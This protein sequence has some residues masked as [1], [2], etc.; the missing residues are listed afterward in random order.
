MRLSVVAL[1]ITVSLMLAA[2]GEKPAEKSELVV[3]EELQVIPI[4]QACDD[5]SIKNSLVAEVRSKIDMALIEVLNDNADAKKLDLARLAQSHLSMLNI[6][7][8]KVQSQDGACQAQLLLSLPQDEMTAAE[9]YFKKRDVSLETLLDDADA[10]YVDGYVVGDI[11]YNKT[12]DKVVIEDSP[13]L[14]L[15]AKLTAAATHTIATDKKVVDIG[16][17]AAVVVT[18][19]EPIAVQPVVKN[20][21]I[22]IKADNQPSD[23]QTDEVVK[24]ETVKTEDTSTKPANKNTDKNANKNTDKSSAVKDAELTTKTVTTKISTAKNND[25]AASDDN[26]SSS[27]PDEKG[28]AVKADEPKKQT[29]SEQ[30]DET[31]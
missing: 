23:S 5:A 4:E 1:M 13:M 21:T 10:E 29:I 12:G 15:F 30:T 17:R 28:P 8:Q 26:N 14:A 20:R 24:S 25:K 7:L 3:Q 22:D 18:P 27:T 6:D 2:C 16:G 9:K 31:Y 11:T 19:L